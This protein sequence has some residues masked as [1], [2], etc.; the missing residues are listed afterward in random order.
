M[1]KEVQLISERKKTFFFL[2]GDVNDYGMFCQDG[3]EYSSLC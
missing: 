1:D 3:V 2:R